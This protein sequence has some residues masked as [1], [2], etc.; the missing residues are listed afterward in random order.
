MSALRKHGVGL[1]LEDNEIM[2]LTTTSN[3]RLYEVCNKRYDFIE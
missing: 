1:E 3:R 2:L